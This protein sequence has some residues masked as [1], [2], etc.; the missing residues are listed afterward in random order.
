MAYQYHLSDDS[1]IILEYL[2]DSFQ[3]AFL[4]ERFREERIFFSKGVNKDSFLRCKK[5][6]EK[7]P[8]L[9]I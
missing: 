7:N 2:N 5:W 1:K 4:I 3:G 6:I 9:V 8:E